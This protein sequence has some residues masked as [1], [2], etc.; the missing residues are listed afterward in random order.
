MTLFPLA[1]RSLFLILLFL[2]N[3]LFPQKDCIDPRS[4]SFP[5]EVDGEKNKAQ[6]L[7]Q[8]EK[9][10]FTFW[11]RIEAKKDG[12]LNI[13]ISSTNPKDLYEVTLYRYN[14]E[15]VCQ[16]L[17][18]GN[19]TPFER[20]NAP[21]KEERIKGHNPTG[22]Q[23]LH[24]Q[25]GNSYY[26]SVL[27]VRGK[28]CG[29]IATFT[30]KGKERTYHARAED[31]FQVP[32][33]PQKDEAQKEKKQV[34]VRTGLEDSSDGA[35]IAGELMIMNR[36]SGK[37]RFITFKG[38][39]ARTLQLRKGVPYRFSGEALGYDEKS[40]ERS[41]ETD[42][43]F[44]LALSRKEKGERIVLK[45]IYFHPNTYAFREG[46]QRSIEA[47]HRFLEQRPEVRIEIQGHTASD[48][49]IEEKNPLYRDKG[50]AWNFTGTAEEL[51]LLRAKAVKK[52]LVSKGIEEERLEAKGFGASRKRVKNP[53]DQEEEQKNMRVEIRILQ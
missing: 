50:K 15:E 24:L 53:Q 52:E 37:K 42:S 39:S 25:K 1:V 38:D 18:H 40:T 4:V 7:E 2:P 23:K 44:F 13:R 27:H 10:R 49:T 20:P 35:R 6:V 46:S 45:R 30:S 31:C 22:F 11:Y 17:V 5:L 12:P 3:L 28:G 33:L 16:E 26:L 29:H 14:G 43:S 34:T 47:L 41:F 9:E 19:L 32:E 48:R 51:S 21:W 8:S 36:K